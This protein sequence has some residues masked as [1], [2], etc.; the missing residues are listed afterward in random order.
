[1]LH[2]LQSAWTDDDDE[3]KESL[4]LLYPRMMERGAFEDDNAVC[5]HRVTLFVVYTL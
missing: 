2:R 3:D 5:D 4:L 1:M